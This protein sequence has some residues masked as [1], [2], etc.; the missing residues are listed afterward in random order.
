MLKKKVGRTNNPN[1]SIGTIK[2]SSYQGKLS[3]TV[4]NEIYIEN[5]SD[6]GDGRL[7]EN[8]GD[9]N[10]ILSLS[11]ISEDESKDL[12][13]KQLDKDGKS[14]HSIEDEVELNIEVALQGHSKP[15]EVAKE[16]DTNMAEEVSSGSQ[17]QL[18]DMSWANQS[19]LLNVSVSGG[20][21]EKEIKTI[22]SLL[23]LLAQDINIRA[24][25]PQGLYRDL[26]DTMVR[27]GHGLN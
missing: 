27:D 13:V 20:G 25:T 6:I 10:D 7:K 9:M 3:K 24:L 8:R 1:D 23:G 15:Q 5:E 21:M 22:K 4:R 12:Q 11:G 26:N 17:V 19:D 14:S 16:P 18:A 2:K